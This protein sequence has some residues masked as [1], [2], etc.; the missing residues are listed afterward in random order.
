MDMWVLALYCV[1]N[2]YIHIISYIRNTNGMKWKNNLETCKIH[3]V[4]RHL[5]QTPFDQGNHPCQGPSSWDAGRPNP[6]LPGPIAI[7]HSEKRASAHL[8]AAE[9][10]M[11]WEKLQEYHFQIFS[12]TTWTL[13]SWSFSDTLGPSKVVTG[14]PPRYYLVYIQY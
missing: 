3:Q 4:K 14:D 13:H 2:I 7:S 11:V 5:K 10:R 1:Y 12:D 6:L 8:V 9:T